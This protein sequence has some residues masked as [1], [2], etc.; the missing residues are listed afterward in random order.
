MNLPGSKL[1]RFVSVGAVFTSPILAGAVAGH[2]LDD[3]FHT[4][5]WLTISL[6]AM[7]FIT[8][9]Y[10]LIRLV[11]SFMADNPK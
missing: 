2:L 1:I 7:G 8:G 6:L 4:E 9:L 3:Y 11:N 5:P 10:N